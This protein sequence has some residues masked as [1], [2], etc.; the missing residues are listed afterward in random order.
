MSE[1]RHSAN[2]SPAH[3]NFNE[4]SQD[5]SYKFFKDGEALQAELANLQQESLNFINDE[6]SLELAPGTFPVIDLLQPA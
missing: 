5:V 2:E 6:I 4:A 3:F 1:S